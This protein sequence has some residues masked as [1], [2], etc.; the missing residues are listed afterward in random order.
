MPWMSPEA[1]LNVSS[2]PLSAAI[3]NGRNVLGE[4]KAT[5]ALVDGTPSEARKLLIFVHGY[6]HREEV[7]AH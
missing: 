7:E 6:R 2:I 1:S 3:V 5:A 4:L